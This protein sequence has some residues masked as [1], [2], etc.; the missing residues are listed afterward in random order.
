MNMRRETAPSAPTARPAADLERCYTRS[1]LTLVKLRALLEA[2]SEMRVRLQRVPYV[3]EVA[4]VLD[5][6]GSSQLPL[7]TVE[8]LVN[9]VQE[10]GE[11]DVLAYLTLK[12][13]E[14]LMGRIHHA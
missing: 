13:L 3:T 14:E 12:R 11:S 5:D 10:A 1:E 4:E 2:L 8:I 6:L 7:S 9:V